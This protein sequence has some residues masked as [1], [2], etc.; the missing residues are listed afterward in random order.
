MISFSIEH[1]IKE[2]NDFATH[3]LKNAVLSVFRL[4]D[5]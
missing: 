3:A 1:V 4:G 5:Q 2:K